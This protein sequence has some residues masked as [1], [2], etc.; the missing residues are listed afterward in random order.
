MNL[1]D[2]FEPIPAS[3]IEVESKKVSLDQLDP[4]MLR[5]APTMQFVNQLAEDPDRVTYE[6]YE[7]SQLTLYAGIDCV[8]TS[9]IFGKLWPQLITQEPRI[10]KGAD[11]KLIRGHAPAIIDSIQELEIPAQE[12]LIDLEISGVKYSVERNQFLSEKMLVEINELDEQIWIQAGS[13]FNPNS[14]AEIAELLYDTKGFIPPFS[15]KKGEPAVDGQALLML[16]GLDPIGKNRMAKDPTQQWLVELAKRRDLNSLRN[17][18]LVNYV[19]DFVKRDG[20]IH[21]SYNQFGTSSHRISS[22]SPNLTQL[23]NVKHGYNLRHSYTVD[24][25]NAFVCFDFKGAELKVLANLAKEKSMLEA[26]VEGRDFHCVSASGM[27]GIPYDEVAGA[28]ADETH[29]MHK[30]YKELRR[31]A[32]VLSFSLC[33]GS[34]AGGIAHQLNLDKSVAQELIDA[35]F[36]AFP[37]VKAF[38]E[39]S[40]HHALTNQYSI[41]PLG[42]RRRQYGTFPA[43]RRTAAYNA[44]LRSGQNFEIQSATSSIGLATFAELNRRTRHLGAKSICTVNVGGLLV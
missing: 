12:F 6:D 2:L 25:E 9:G 36:T 16:A 22:D 4:E 11:G 3:R 39:A 32:K 31:K 10:I 30:D 38:I 13:K 5:T 15:T 37:G 26:I 33:Y 34:S 18:F 24:E 23:P 42:Q 43:F 8:A 21:A 35:Y 40:H 29:P 19:K 7:L 14:G 1:T 28:V 20:R 17:T 44:S 41:T 27:R